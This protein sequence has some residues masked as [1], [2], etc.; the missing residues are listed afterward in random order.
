MIRYKGQRGCGLLDAK[1][2]QKD[3][4]CLAILLKLLAERNLPGDESCSAI[5]GCGLYE[6][7]FAGTTTCGHRTTRVIFM[8]SLMR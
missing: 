1:K 5:I 4:Q 2:A 6:S 8:C 7:K 3:D